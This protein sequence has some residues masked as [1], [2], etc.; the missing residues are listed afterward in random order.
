MMILFAAG[1]AGRAETKPDAE[2]AD[3]LKQLGANSY[4]EREKASKYLWENA[5]SPGVF[6]LIKKTA[7]SKDPEVRSRALA[8]IKK[9]NKGILFGLPG[10]IVDKIRALPRR[11]P[12]NKRHTIL[13]I[14]ESGPA[15]ARVVEM[16]ASNLIA[17]NFT[18][19][20]APINQKDINLLVKKNSRDIVGKYLENPKI[21][22]KTA[23]KVFLAAAISS[24]NRWEQYAYWTS[25]RGKTK[26]RIAELERRVKRGGRRNNAWKALLKR[27]YFLAD[28]YDKALALDVGND[29]RAV[30]YA[31]ALDTGDYEKVWWP[32]N[33]KKQNFTYLGWAV[34]LLNLQ[35]KPKKAEL[36]LKKALKKVGADGN[37]AWYALEIMLI[38]DMV[39]KTTELYLG[40]NPPLNPA[41]TQNLPGLY[42]ETVSKYVEKT[43]K[44]PTEYIQF[45]AIHGEK[46][47]AKKL[48]EKLIGETLNPDGSL[49]NKIK[50]KTAIETIANLAKTA[51]AIGDGQTAR[52]LELT[53]LRQPKAKHMEVF[54]MIHGF[55]PI[56]WITY[57]KLKHPNK[58]DDEIIDE[59][60]KISKRN[61]LKWKGA[62]KIFDDAKQTYL[63]KMP[64]KKAALHLPY[65]ARLYRWIGNKKKTMEILELIAEIDPSREHIEILAD[66]KAMKGDFAEAAELY[67]KLAEADPENKTPPYLRGLALLKDGQKKKGRAIMAETSMEIFDDDTKRNDLVTN[68]IDK[69]YLDEAEKEETIRKKAH[70]PVN[71]QARHATHRLAYVLQE[72]KEFIKAANYI[73]FSLFGTLNT[74][75][76]YPTAGSYVRLKTWYHSLRAK[77]L[78]K[79]KK[80]DDACDEFI[81]AL[82]LS[83]FCSDIVIDTVKK[84][85]L[86]GRK[87]LGDKLYSK[88][89]AL[90]EKDLEALPKSPLLKNCIAWTMASLERDL[91]KA[92]KLV[93]EALDSEPENAAYIDTL[94]EVLFKKGDR[95]KAM[96]NQEKAVALT[97]TAADRDNLM[98][99]LEH[100]KKDPIPE[101]RKKEGL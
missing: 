4:E 51:L 67:K 48:L 12:E 53:A 2:I 97:T 16:F 77:G 21:Y 1:F 27:L 33:T 5:L 92:E 87:D 15:G 36:Y 94:S 60:Y 82:E 7:R 54:K 59:Y 35:G 55:A 26:K 43:G 20:T 74:N 75:T 72:K 68:L 83:H 89:I 73:M 61:L 46:G 28:E 66:Q 25:L 65:L 80:Y 100:F 91:D 29:G 56:F 98:K 37:N 24:E 64:P 70:L 63:E 11:T 52:K 22:E 3:A 13:E 38:N 44:I 88:Y 93:A 84:F 50:K 101:K 90:L 34:T 10:E 6:P 85:D 86:E 57:L 42:M 32:D 9:I 99:R 79:K 18:P 17:G 62:E 95:T 96:E 78:F 76:A 14:L 69:N 23:E 71:W 40:T 30:D 49:K 8:I 47:K 19:S 31:I 81:R 58:P 39:E 45:L 41:I